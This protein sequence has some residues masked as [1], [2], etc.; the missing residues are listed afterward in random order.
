MSLYSCRSCEDEPAFVFEVYHEP[1]VRPTWDYP[2][3]GPLAEVENADDGKCPKCG[4]DAP[5]ETELLQA[6]CEDEQGAAEDAAERAD[7]SRRDR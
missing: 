2:G 5:T 4:A 6:I 3:E 1:Y 7:D